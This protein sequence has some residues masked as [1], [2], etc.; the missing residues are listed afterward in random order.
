MEREGT[1]KGNESIEEAQPPP[2]G[3]MRRRR[4]PG[5]SKGKK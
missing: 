2:L 3:I 4:E 1:K 5:L